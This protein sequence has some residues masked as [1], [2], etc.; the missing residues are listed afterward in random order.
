MNE[1]TPQTIVT[2]ALY[3]QISI[4][5]IMAFA[6]ALIGKTKGRWDH[7]T[8]GHRPAILICFIIVTFALLV[9]SDTYRVVVNPLVAFGTSSF[10]WTLALRLVF[11]IDIITVTLLV[12]GTNGSQ[13]SPFQPL[14]FL[15]PTLA[16]FL[17]EP[18]GRVIFY[19]ILVSV[20]FTCLLGWF[21]EVE[22]IDDD[23]RK[24][25]R[26]ALIFVSISCLILACWIGLITRKS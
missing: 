15:I 3:A 2:G 1:L 17:R 16:L 12:K 13:N 10:S 20:S 9:F 18:K 6:T 22:R 11:I 14:Y 26:M 5:V 8:Y 19:A 21:N 24:K 7:E 25:Y 4:I 23:L